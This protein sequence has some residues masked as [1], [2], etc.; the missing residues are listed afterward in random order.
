[1]HG[2][3]STGPRTLEGRQKATQIGTENLRRWHA[4][5]CSKSTP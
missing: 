1:M 3:K 4:E 2:G 5:R